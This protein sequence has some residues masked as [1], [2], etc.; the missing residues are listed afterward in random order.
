MKLDPGFSPC[1][2]INSKWIKD[3]NVRPQTLKLVQERIEK[4]QEHLDKGNNV[5]N[6]IQAAQQLKERFDKWDYLRFKT[7]TFFYVETVIRLKRQYTEWEKIFASYTSDK[8]LITRI[9]REYK[10]IKLSK[11]QSLN[12]NRYK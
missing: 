11:N 8:G 6:R 10:K 12:E 3:F 5:L 9:Y 4:T 1:T 7:S 2:N